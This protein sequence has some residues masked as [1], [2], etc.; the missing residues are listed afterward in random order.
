MGHG[1][2][3][4]NLK[5]FNKKMLAKK[6]NIEHATTIELELQIGPHDGERNDEG[7]IS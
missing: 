5:G 1:R 4:N 6:F 7:L 2:M 3:Q